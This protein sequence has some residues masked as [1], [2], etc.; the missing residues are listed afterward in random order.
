M[1]A[2][3]TNIL[4]RLIIQE[5]IHQTQMV[6]QLLKDTKTKHEQL[7]VPSLVIL[8]TIWVLKKCYQFS[9]AEI[10]EA[11]L[12][13][14]SLTVFKIEHSQATQTCLNYA[15]TNTF[16]LSDLIIGAIAQANHCETTLTFDNKASKSPYFEK[17]T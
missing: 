11:V 8:E 5:D 3:D 4:I 6:K 17:I 1:K 7:F 2:V 15:K 13:I 9:R 10:I 16:D 14:I 12:D